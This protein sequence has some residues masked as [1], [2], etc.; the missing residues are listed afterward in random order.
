V[1]YGEWAQYLH[2]LRMAQSLPFEPGWSRAAD[3]VVV[4]NRENALRDGK[5]AIEELE[6][7]KMHAGIALKPLAVQGTSHHV[8]SAP[9]LFS[10][11][12]G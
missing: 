11:T 3:D 12:I 2:L 10:G 5:V 7:I 8:K 1:I 4:G 6:A 9:Q